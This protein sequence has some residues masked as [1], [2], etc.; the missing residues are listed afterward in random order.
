MRTGTSSL[1][2]LLMLVGV[3]C[4]LDS[5]PADGT[6]AATFNLETMATDLYRNY[7]LGSATFSFATSDNLV[8][9][10]VVRDPGVTGLIVTSSQIL[11]ESDAVVSSA[12]LDADADLT[13]T[14]DETAL[15][16]ATSSGNVFGFSPD[17]TTVGVNLG[18]VIN[19]DTTGYA[20][21]ATYVSSTTTL[22]TS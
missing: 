1:V 9:R 17:G 13:T 18:V 16:L 3:G 4:G 5:P 2:V 7:T 14:D 22:P 19:G 20:S 21:S 15:T 6:G 12:L 10:G 11:D 8:L